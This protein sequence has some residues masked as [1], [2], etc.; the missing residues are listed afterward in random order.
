M[1]STCTRVISRTLYEAQIAITA[2]AMFLFNLTVTHCATETSCSPFVTII[3]RGTNKYCPKINFQTYPPMAQL[4][5]YISELNSPHF[6]FWLYFAMESPLRSSGQEFLATHPEVPGSIFW[7]VAGLSLVRIT[8]ELF[9]G[10]S[11]SGL[12]KCRL[13]AV[14]IRCADHATPSIH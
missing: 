7:E 5:A 8:E 12:K 11:G 3:C 14:G 1:Q 9:Q 6:M 10:N 4:T 13:M 2:L